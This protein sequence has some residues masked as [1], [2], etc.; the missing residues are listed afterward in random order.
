M[1]RVLLHLNVSVKNMMTK[2]LVPNVTKSLVCGD[3]TTD[4]I[5]DEDVDEVE[6]LDFDISEFGSTSDDEEES[7]YFD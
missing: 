4:K 5:D 1:N 3:N 2:K 6:E 7:P